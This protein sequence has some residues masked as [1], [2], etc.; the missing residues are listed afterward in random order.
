M[1]STHRGVGEGVRPGHNISCFH[2]RRLSA[3]LKPQARSRPVARFPATGQS[4]APGEFSK[5]LSASSLYPTRD[6]SRWLQYF[7]ADVV[8][9]LDQS[10]AHSP[11]SSTNTKPRAT[12]DRQYYRLL[13]PV[14]SKLVCPNERDATTGRGIVEHD[15]KTSPFLF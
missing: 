4:S 2:V 12:A 11:R 15:R 3:G 5:T 6:S 1:Y 7:Q 10:Y 9:A 13:A 14:K 8:P